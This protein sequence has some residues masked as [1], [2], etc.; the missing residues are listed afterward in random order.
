MLPFPEE[1]PT[2]QKN[3]AQIPNK[4]TPSHLINAL[5]TSLVSGFKFQDFAVARISLVHTFDPSGCTWRAPEALRV[6]F[7]GAGGDHIYIYIC[8]EYI[9]IYMLPPRS[10]ARN[11]SGPIYFVYHAPQARIF[12]SS[13]LPCAVRST[14]SGSGPSPPLSLVEAIDLLYFKFEN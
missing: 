8:V 10:V 12:E 1:V 13:Q 6:G 4:N 7:F 11:S 3:E 2:T 14:R 9:Y 5:L